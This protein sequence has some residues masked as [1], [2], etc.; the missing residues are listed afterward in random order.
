[1]NADERRQ[2]QELNRQDSFRYPLEGYAEAAKEGAGKLNREEH[3]GRGGR[4]LQLHRRGRGGRQ[5]TDSRFNPKAAKTTPRAGIS[6]DLPA[7]CDTV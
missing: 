5:A 7:A 1:M 2:N 4:R 3:E 6:A